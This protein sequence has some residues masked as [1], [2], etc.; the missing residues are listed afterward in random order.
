MPIRIVRLTPEDIAVARSTFVMMAAVFE[1]GGKPLSDDYLRRLLARDDFFAL[2]AFSEKTPVGG[3][4]AHVL[5]LTRLERSEL[6]IFDVA[7]RADHQRKGIGR[8]LV[9]ALRGAAAEIGIHDVFVPAD[10]ED[11][12]ALE[13]YRALGGEP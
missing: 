1:E 8:Q 6:F 13:F 10:D 2:A 11:N 12:H 3:I 7:V 5:P 4:T 9:A